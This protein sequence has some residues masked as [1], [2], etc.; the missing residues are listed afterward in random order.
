MA[1]F[2][3]PSGRL[4]GFGGIAASRA[5]QSTEFVIIVFRILTVAIDD[6]SQLLLSVVIILVLAQYLIAHLH[7]GRLAECVIGISYALTVRHICLLQIPF[8]YKNATLGDVPSA[9]FL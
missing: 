3:V 8:N 7:R 9:A 1:V 5:N 4:G 2:I 6:F